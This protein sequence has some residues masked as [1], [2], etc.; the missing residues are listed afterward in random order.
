MTHEIVLLTIQTRELTWT[1]TWTKTHHFTWSSRRYLFAASLDAEII[2]ISKWDSFPGRRSMRCVQ[3][4]SPQVHP[5]CLNHDSNIHAIKP[6]YMKLTLFFSLS[7]N[8]MCADSK[9]WQRNMKCTVNDRLYQCRCQFPCWK[10][11]IN[12]KGIGST[13]TVADRTRI[14]LLQFVNCWTLYQLTCHQ[15]L[16]CCHHFPDSNKLFT[17]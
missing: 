6:S 14:L 15:Q 7:Q 13:Q 4:N 8:A 12:I 5:S 2:K 9:T 3:L 10:S 1:Q 16:F 11:S 17:F